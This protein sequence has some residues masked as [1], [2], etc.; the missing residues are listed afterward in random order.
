MFKVNFIMTWHW[1][2][3]KAREGHVC[4]Y[5]QWQKKNHYFHHRFYGHSQ[6]HCRMRTNDIDAISMM[7]ILLFQHKNN[8]RLKWFAKCIDFFAEYFEFDLNTK[9][10]RKSCDFFPSEICAEGSVCILKVSNKF[11]FY[12]K[13]WFIFF[14]GYSNHNLNFVFGINIKA[15]IALLQKKK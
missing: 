13:C 15:T 2:G 12:L 11:I 4:V 8:S 5:F 9:I 1:I 7:M 3:T 10:W 14:S 6:I